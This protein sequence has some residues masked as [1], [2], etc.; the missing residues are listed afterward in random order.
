MT[1]GVKTA[2]VFL[3]LSFFSGPVFSGETLPPAAPMP[4]SY[5]IPATTIPG[6]GCFDLEEFQSRLVFLPVDAVIR[7]HSVS[8]DTDA[9]H[10]DGT[11]PRDNF[12]S[13][14][15]NSL[16]RFEEARPIIFQASIFQIEQIGCELVRITGSSGP[17]DYM[18][19]EA[20]P[21]SLKLEEVLSDSA[22]A[23][24]DQ[25][26]IIYM[27]INANEMEI[28]TRSSAMDFCLPYSMLMFDRTEHLRWN[29]P[30]QMTAIR[31]ENM[32]QAYLRTL[33]QAMD[34][35]HSSAKKSGSGNTTLERKPA[36]HV[37]A[38]VSD[39]TILSSLS[40]RSSL[41]VCPYSLQ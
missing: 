38:S 4:I 8:V 19:T 25:Q 36:K 1:F 35:T 21:T 22:H 6:A 37:Q 23:S 27:W 15:A 29:S 28:R 18:I 20:T 13:V 2:S 41:T 16:Y 40:V 33:T 3:A 9:L 34:E 24:S 5:E 10:L 30:K 31:H 26:I 17:I 32:D 14:L 39:L 12:L 7:K 11:I